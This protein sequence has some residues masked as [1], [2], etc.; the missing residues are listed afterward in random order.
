[1][2]HGQIFLLAGAPGFLK[3]LQEYGFKTFSPYIDETYDSIDD[4][5]ERGIALVGTLKGIIELS[6]EDFATL[7]VNCQEA[8][9][10]NR[11]LLTDKAFMDRLISSQVVKAIETLWD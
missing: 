11:Q 7:L 3:Q 4:P 8:I 10:H 2:L 5:V 9:Q 1:M 6:E